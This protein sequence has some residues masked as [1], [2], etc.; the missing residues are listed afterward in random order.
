M[1]I[2]L[3]SDHRGFKLK[4]FL[5][6]KLQALNYPTI[7][8][9]AYKY[10]EDDD[11]PD[12]AKLVAFKISK[13]PKNCRGIVICGSGVGVDITVN[14]FPKVRSVLGFSVKQVKASRSDDDVNV[15]SLAADYINK[16]ESWRLVESFLKT[17]FKNKLKY[18]RRINK[19]DK[20]LIHK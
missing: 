8:L 4:N 9:G 14:R 20:I 7:D 11:Y 12:F 3:A 2:Y 10:Q 6:T 18:K 19:I 1:K 15:I 17:K 5:I 16:Q 13:N